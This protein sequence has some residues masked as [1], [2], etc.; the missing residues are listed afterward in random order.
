MSK[1]KLYRGIWIVVLCLK[2]TSDVAGT[3]SIIN[4]WVGEW[5]RGVGIWVNRQ[6]GHLWYTKRGLGVIKF[7]RWLVSKGG[8]KNEREIRW[9]WVEKNI[10]VF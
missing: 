6:W 7:V 8:I 3:R 4:G 9:W 1:P 10:L 2:G 5:S